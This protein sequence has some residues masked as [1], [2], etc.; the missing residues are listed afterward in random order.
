MSAPG[1]ACS[2]SMA[3][4]P[5]RGSTSVMRALR[6]RSSMWA[7]CA[8]LMAQTR[9]SRR[10]SNWCQCASARSSAVC[11]RS[12]AVLASNTSERA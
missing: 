8:M 2:S 4:T 5:S 7:L 1:A 6:R 12:S 11:T 3:S 10:W 9:M